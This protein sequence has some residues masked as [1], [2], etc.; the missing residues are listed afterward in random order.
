[1]GADVIDVVANLEVEMQV[2]VAAYEGATYL[3]LGVA[4]V[5]DGFQTALGCLFC[6]NGVVGIDEGGA[7]FGRE[8]AVK[9][10]FS[11]DNTLKAAEAFE[12]G[13]AHIGDKAE[14]GVGDATEVGYLA[15][16]AG[17]HLYDGNLCVG[18]DG[19]EREGHTEVV[20]EVAGGG[21][22]AVAFGQD[23]VDKL[24]GGGFAVGASDAYERDGELAAVACGQLLQGGKHVGHHNAAIVHLVL[25]VA[26]DAQ[27]GALLQCLGREDVAVEGLPTE[28]KEN[29]A[30]GNLPRVGSHLPTLK[31]GLI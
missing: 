7:P 26:D 11:L 4:A 8:V 14:V 31:I 21:V 28:G 23:G 3:G 12:V 27:C 16:M 30:G 29:A 18:G 6:K 15:R 17:P 25:R 5:G 19:K 22:G 2:G 13:A 10:C 24:L 9:F 1:M 20:V